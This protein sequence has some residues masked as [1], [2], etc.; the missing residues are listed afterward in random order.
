MA[1]KRLETKRVSS[2]CAEVVAEF[3]ILAAIWED[4]MVQ[5]CQKTLS[6]D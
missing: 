5:G 4:G 1:V 6:L 3:M 2:D